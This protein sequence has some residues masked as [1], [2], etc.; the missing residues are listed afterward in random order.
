MRIVAVTSLPVMAIL[1]NNGRRFTC[2]RRPAGTARR[3]AAARCVGSARAR[4]GRA[5]Q[6]PAQS[7]RDRAQLGHAARRPPLG[8]GERGACR[9]RRQ[10]HLGGRP[11]RRERV[12]R[13]DR[14]SDRQTRSQRQGGAELRRRPDRV[15][16]RHGRRSAGQHL[17]RRRARGHGGGAREVSRLEEQGTR[18]AEVQPARQAADDARHAGRSGRS[19]REVHRTERRAGRSR[20]QHLRRRNAQ[21]AVPRSESAQRH[22]PHLEVRP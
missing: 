9:C 17:D 4:Q 18:G 10:A 19:A 21:R 13:I 14:R 11:L 7:L 6:Q 16:A 3:G 12:H 2:S 5:D 1:S 22:R 8:I 15:A 20:R